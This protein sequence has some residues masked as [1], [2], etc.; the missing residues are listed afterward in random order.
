MCII[1]LLLYVR[2]DGSWYQKPRDRICSAPSYV[3]TI[4]PVDYKSTR[5]IENAGVLRQKRYMKRR[6]KKEKWYTVSS[7]PKFTS[8]QFYVHVR[9]FC[10]NNH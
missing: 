9:D 8:K 3:S 5:V 2:N 1:Y 10:L 7:R 6:E 4:F